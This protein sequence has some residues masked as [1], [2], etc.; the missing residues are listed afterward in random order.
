MRATETKS[1]LTDNRS[2]NLLVKCVSG[3]NP[4][5]ALTNVIYHITDPAITRTPVYTLVPADCPYELTI[6]ATLSDGSPLPAPLTMAPPTLSV[7]EANYANTAT[8]V[9]RFTAT[10]PKS[11][12]TNSVVTVNVTILCT[13]TVDL[14]SGAI[15]NF[16]YQIV[17]ATPNNSVTPL[18]IYD[19]NPSACASGAFSYELVYGGTFPSFIN[20]YPT[21]DVLVMTQNVV[22]IGTYTFQ[23][24]VTDPL[25][26]LVNTSNSFVLTILGPNYATAL[27]WVAA[28]PIPDQNYLVGSSNPMLSSP[29][30]TVTPANADVQYSYSLG[31]STPGFIT[32]NAAIPPLIS[33][34][35]TNTADTGIYSVDYTVTEVFSGLSIT[36]TF[37]ATVSC[38]TGIT[39][40]SSIAPTTY[41]ITDPVIP[42]PIPA[43]SLT[44]ATCPYELVVTSVT[45]A[46]N[47]ALPASITF[48]GANTVNI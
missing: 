8:Y 14:I 33:I 21:T 46:D 47:S 24:K 29:A 9:V 27:A 28:T 3:I 38:V 25:S 39:Q 18:P 43:Y 37:I 26:G 6:A 20:R 23:V 41:Y 4:A 30:F 15:A 42:I 13:K 40:L 12:V 17:L 45:L 48:D 31:A 44:P 32:L 11:G 1:G 7:F 5:G 10:D 36:D 2:F 22:D 35:T 34:F 19:V 16:S